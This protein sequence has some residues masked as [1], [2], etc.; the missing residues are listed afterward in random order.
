MVSP[1]VDLEVIEYAVTLAC[2]A[3]S[4]HNSQ[5]WLLT[6]DRDGLH[7][8]LDR[9]RVVRSD[10]GQRQALISCGA[11]LDHLGAAMA[12]RGW[13]THVE[14]LPD[15][16]RPDHLAA[17]GLSR[18]AI[19]TDEH[20]RRAQAIHV[21]RSDRLPMDPV[22]DWPTFETA[23]HRFPHHT[24]MLIDVLSEDDRGQ[25]AEASE[26][27]DKLRQLDSNYQDT[28]RDWT[29]PYAGTDRIP[30][31]ALTSANEFDRVPLARRFPESTHPPRRPTVTA[32]GATVVVLSTREDT[33]DALIGCGQQLS[34]ILLEATMAGL[35]TCT[36][37]HVTELYASRHI[38]ERL[39][40]RP[41]PQVLVRVGQA[42]AGEPLPVPTP[43]R[44]LS[45][46]LT[47][48]C[49]T[50]VTIPTAN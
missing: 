12:G 26:L 27:A 41:R 19:L 48:K 33:R 13:R 45:D 28:M 37:S 2:R 49:P 46:V 39:T 17:I 21:R 31:S 20:R 32:D 34:S 18:A 24:E 15:P 1:G 16:D 6:S 35:A 23:L 4:Y 36:L 43:R 9:N 42:P 25:L 3:P 50:V 29:A 44:E 38:L 10:P 7:L 8:Y 47:S 22:S 11:A 14:R 30:Y 40:G 5:P